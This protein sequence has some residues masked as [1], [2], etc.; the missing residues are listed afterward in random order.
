M[1]GRWDRLIHAYLSV[2]HDVVWDMVAGQVPV[3]AQ[4]VGQVVEQEAGWLSPVPI[5]ACAPSLMDRRIHS[6]SAI[7]SCS[8]SRGALRTATTLPLNPL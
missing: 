1:A 5:Y 7:I 8:V 4:Q 2:G 3:L 6:A